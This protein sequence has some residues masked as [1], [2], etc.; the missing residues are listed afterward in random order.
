MRLIRRESDW[1]THALEMSGKKFSDVKQKRM[2]SSS[3]TG[4]I[5]RFLVLSV[6]TGIY[7]WTTAKNFLPLRFFPGYSEPNKS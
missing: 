6:M 2:T 4:E 1:V 7:E 3:Y 5:I